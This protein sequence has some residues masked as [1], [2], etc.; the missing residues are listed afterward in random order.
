MKF[1]G[2]SSLLIQDPAYAQACESIGRGLSG[3]L[4]IPVGARPA[5][6]AEIARNLADHHNAHAHKAPLVVVTATGREAQS[7]VQALQQW[8]PAHDVALFP[9]WETLP[10]ERLSPQADTIAQRVAVLRRL[11]HPMHNNPNARP[12]RILV[13]PVRAFVQPVIGGLGDDEPVYVRVGDRVD[14]TDLVA[15]LTHLGYQSVDMVEKRGHFSVRGGIIDVFVAHEKHPFRIELWGDEVEDIRIFSVSDQR[16]IEQATHGMWAT[17]CQELLLTPQVRERARQAAQHYSGAA[18]LLEL[19]A[20]GIHAPGI[21]SLAPLIVP[22]ME[23][24]LDSIPEASPILVCDPERVRSRAHDLVATTEEFLTAA[25]SAAAGGGTIPLEADH[26]S[27]IDYEELRGKA[28]RIWWDLTS[29]PPAELLESL[30]VSPATTG[31]T[32][33][34]PSYT[35]DTQAIIASPTIMAV[36]MREAHAYRGDIEKA[37]S[38]LT[39]LARQSW[40]IVLASDA[41]GSAQRMTHVLNSAGL[42]A[43][44]VE[45]L[46]V[47]EMIPAIVHVIAAPMG[48]GFVAPDLKFVL[49]TES[50]LTGRQGATTKDMRR[51][52]S[53]RKKGVDPLTLKAGDL[54]VHEHHGIGRF[55][56]LVARTVGRGD[57][58]VT[59]D[60]LVIE[61]APSKRGQPGD[62]LFMP[63]DSLDQIS[64]YTGSDTP[65]LT[66]MGGAEWAKTKARARKAVNEV[67]KELIR[68]YAARQATRGYA[69]S[70]DTPWQR[71][72]EDAFPY[73]E[74]PDQLVTIDEVKADME[75][76]IPMDR[77]LTGDVGYGKTEVAVRAAFKAVQDGKQV[78]IL[79]P[80][81]LL[82]QQHV[83]TFQERYAGFPVTV[84]ALSRFSTPQETERVRQGLASGG[85]DVVIGTHALLTGTVAFKDLGLVVIDEEQRFGV[86][87]KETL[88]ALR[89]DVDVLS[90]SATPIPRTL[91]MAV[92]GIREMSILQTPPEERQPV[93]T[94]VGPH[95]DAQVIAAI[96][97]ELLRDGQVFY[98]HNRVD[99]INSVADHISQL[100]PE[101]RVRVAHGKLTEHQ[102]EEVIIDFWNHDFD[103]LVCTTIVETGLDISNANTLIVDR[104]DIFGLS[105]LHQLRGRVGRGR[106]RA[107]AYFFYPQDRTLTETAHERLSTIAAHSELGSG[108]AVAQKDL[109]IRGAGNLL[110]GAQSGHIEGVGFDLY[111]RMVADAVAAY[112]G[113]KTENMTDVRLDVPVD[114]HIPDSYIRGERLRLEM[115]GRIASTKTP[116]E[117]SDVRVELEDRYG[118]VPREVNLLFAVARLREVIRAAG[119]EE[120]MLQGKYVRFSPVQLA[121]SQVIRLKRLHPGAVIKTAVRQV[122]IP[123]PMTSRI[124]GVPLTDE[125]LLEWIRDV[126]TKILV[127]FSA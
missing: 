53:R 66:K 111:V 121:D 37:T 54:I 17:A 76:P 22:H 40:R 118:P 29:L 4:V 83:E 57:S 8:V 95:T 107:Y 21:E 15:R 23:R 36:G 52:P 19:A 89:T 38:D 62:R 33:D 3:T 41:P 79:V 75:K 78:A 28:G 122:L 11:K 110:G 69:F 72:L 14:M 114:A 93:L 112:K 105:Q 113:E 77:L 104:A 115:Y 108:L 86:E 116:Q 98:V 42:A 127:P 106:E 50:D 24:L 30:P 126:V 31:D 120:V 13:C 101:A 88:K 90:M 119:L 73:V 43:R 58:A 49:L 1:A 63:T 59:R 44:L 16:T 20:E 125:P 96:R 102:L 92:S 80:T 71:E 10:H 124:G 117:E 46:S 5:L 12:V 55:I 18:E 34:S 97:R 91:E 2:L 103:V 56:E 70:P 6:I 94:F 81:T 109:E 45:E 67:A 84:A 123:A 51:M 99:S 48:K 60:Y 100:L 47:S 35:G 68:L 65:S 9:A 61:Y 26:A 25:W 85:V 87:H 32:D 64:K 7:L 39:D 74:T 27:F 82:V